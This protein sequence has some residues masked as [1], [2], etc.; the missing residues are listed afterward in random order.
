MNN[1]PLK[2]LSKTFRHAVKI[3]RFLEVRYVWI[4]SLCIVQDD[5]DD[6]KREASRMGR[7]YKNALLTVAAVSSSGGYTGCFVEYDPRSISPIPITITFPL[8]DSDLQ[9]HVQ[10][11]YVRPT[12][13][14]DPVD[15]TIGFQREPLWQRAWVL[16]ERL[17][18]PRLLR[19]SHV[20]MSWRCRSEQASERLPE[21][22][23][24]FTK[25]SPEEVLRPTILGL[26]NFNL[27]SKDKIPKAIVKPI[28]EEL[29]SLYNA[30][31]DLVMLYGKC[32][33]TVKSDIFPAI[34][35]IAEAIA[36]ATGE[37][38]CAGLW[39]PDLHRGLLWTTPESTSRRQDLR[40]YR[41]PSWSWASLPATCTFW[42]RE[43]LQ[44]N[45]DTSCF[46]VEAVST[47]IDAVNPFGAVSKGNLLVRGLCKKCHPYQE[48]CSSIEAIERIGRSSVD[49]LFDFEEEIAIGS[50]YADNVDRRYLTEVWCVPVWSEDGYTGKREAQCLILQLLDE[51][52][53][54]FMR[55]G[56]AWIRNFDWFSGCDVSTISI[57]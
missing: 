11:G 28:E 29:S 19:F 54:I 41:A 48:E 51:K 25:F 55:V 13:S 16:Q 3:A 42:V 50:Y 17:L 35:G 1:I 37:E 39:K 52:N 56:H 43:L 49:T 20:Q 26:R 32:E 24:L 46:T 23:D 36:M 57:V 9:H 10:S 40:E 6:W 30:W 22:N 14:W 33:L 44:Q 21:G 47:A 31:Y 5:D 34:S 2:T 45:V 12:I 18:S 38:Y 53:W 27:T 8:L 7:Y 4:D 15:D